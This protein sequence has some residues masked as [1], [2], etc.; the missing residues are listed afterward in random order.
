MAAG[1]PKCVWA[2]AVPAN[3]DQVVGDL[4]EG[5]RFREL[6]RMLL[7]RC[8]WWVRSACADLAG[9]C[10]VYGDHYHMQ[11]LHQQQH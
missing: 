8:A 1:L 4:V 3:M 11:Q 6:A 7:Q 10:Q 2:A 9:W 5:V